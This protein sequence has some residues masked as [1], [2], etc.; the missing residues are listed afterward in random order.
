MAR[1]PIEFEDLESL[2]SDEADEGSGTFFGDLYNNGDEC[3]DCGSGP[4]LLRERGYMC[5]NSQCRKVVYP[6]DDV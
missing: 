2:I 3:P 5:P 1:K 6:H 4:L